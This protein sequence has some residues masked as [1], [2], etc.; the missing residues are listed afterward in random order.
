MKM[1]SPIFPSIDRIPGIRNVWSFNLEEEVRLLSDLVDDYPYVSF[2]TEF[3][4]TLV[5]SLDRSEDGEYKAVKWNVDMLKLIQL[6]ITL[7]DEDG[8]LAEVHGLPCSWQFN[9][10]EFSMENDLYALD[11]IDLL[12]QAGIDFGRNQAIGADITVFSEL[13][14]TSGLVLNEHVHWI[15]FAT[16]YDV[17]Y[18]LKALTSRPLPETEGEFFELVQLFFPNLY[19]IKYLP[20]VKFMAELQ[21]GLQR[22]ADS[23]DV[24]RVGISHQAGSDSLLTAFTF[25]KLIRKYYPSLEYVRQHSGKIAGLGDDAKGYM[26]SY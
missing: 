1:D 11:S 26:Y 9:F 2:D 12:Q 10:R 19:D 22:L 25:F 13:L 8:N 23:L 4:G 21:G 3:P 20:V 24:Q 18:L 16:Q 17:G 15:G 6:G 5:R 7:M 14:M